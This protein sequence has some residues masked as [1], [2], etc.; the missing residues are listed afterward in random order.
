MYKIKECD[1]TL[2]ERCKG[3]Q[4][5]MVI[6]NEIEIKNQPHMLVSFLKGHL[7]QLT[8]YCMV[9]QL[10]PIMAW[11]SNLSQYRR[12]ERFSPK[13]TK[14]KRSDQYTFEHSDIYKDQLPLLNAHKHYLPC[15]D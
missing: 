3:F 7:F 6:C 10:V 12:A 1:V 11:F 4:L 15:I 14:S 8:M 2:L 13:T 9:F 5:S